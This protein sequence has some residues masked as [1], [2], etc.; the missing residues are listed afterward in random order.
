MS[1]T[2]QAPPERTDTDITT[3]ANGVRVVT[4]RMPGLASASAS[5]FVRTGSGHESPREN[6]ISHVVEHMAFKGT[7]SRDAAQIN[8]D[9]E[10]LGAEVNAHTDKATTRPTT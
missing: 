1:P 2:T 7:T 10:L 3:L 9:A 6:G 4:I 5:V 8:L